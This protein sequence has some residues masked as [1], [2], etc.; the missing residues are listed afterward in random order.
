VGA[1]LG[2]RGGRS[3][4]SGVATALDI[5][6]GVHNGWITALVQMSLASL[7]RRVSS[8]IDAVPLLLDQLDLLWKAGHRSHLW[9]T[10]RLCSL[11]AG[12]LGNDELAFGLEASVAAASLA[13][14]ALPVDAAALR[15]QDE[16]IRTQHPTESLERT[17]AIAA[18]WD[19]D[20]IVAM[21]R[22]DFQGALDDA[23]G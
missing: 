12:D 14:P 4:A 20:T 16:R 11:V 1:R 6:R 10:I 9:A 8:P 21:I 18:T 7:R 19:V 5:A 13:M 22:A 15:A 17:G 2:D 23:T 3:A